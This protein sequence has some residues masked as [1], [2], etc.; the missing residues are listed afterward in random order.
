LSHRHSSP[1]F[2]VAHWSWVN[3]L[4][5]II[6]DDPSW[7]RRLSQQEKDDITQRMWAE[8]RLKLEPWLEPRL[9]SDRVRLCPH[10]QLV[11]CTER[12]H[13]ELEAELS[14]GEK[15][16]VDQIVL[17]TGYKVDIAR[18]PYLSRNLLQRLETQN[19]FPVLDDHFES[20]IPGL[21]ITSMPA[22]QDFGPFF[23]FTISVRTSAKLI[24]AR[25]AKYFGEEKRA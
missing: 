3:D 16:N 17:A 20:S 13:G 21:F 24:C 4:V 25:L 10:T 18:L 2:E 9:R 5:D 22:T 1:T 23:G 7:F 12:E 14:N 8:G 19:G 15:L 6:A 11:S